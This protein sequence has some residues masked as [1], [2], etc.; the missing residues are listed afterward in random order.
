ML[1]IT[2][3]SLVLSGGLSQLFSMVAPAG[4]P[5]SLPLNTTLI[6][7]VVFLVIGFI[8]ATIS[9]FQIKKWSRYR[10]SNK[11]RCKMSIFTIDDV[12]KTFKTGD[13]SEKS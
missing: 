8:G 10:Q 12:E 13:V 1:L 2:V 3:V 5:F 11:E 9:G 4:M 6:L 7:S